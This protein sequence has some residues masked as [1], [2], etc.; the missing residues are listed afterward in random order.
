M[1]SIVTPRLGY[2][3]APISAVYTPVFAA[4]TFVLGMRI[5]GLNAQ[6]KHGGVDTGKYPFYRRI[7]CVHAHADSHDPH[8]RLR[9]FHG[10]APLTLLIIA[11]AELNGASSRALHTLL[12]TAVAA[13]ILQTEISLRCG[14]EDYKAHMLGFVANH[15]V[16]LAAAG[17][18]AYLTWKRV[19]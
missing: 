16:K 13:R 8:P 4:Y 10:D 7:C 9:S 18:A 5:C 14:K 12:G 6:I 2:Y 1:T 15:G 19:F 17:L 11:L 3:L